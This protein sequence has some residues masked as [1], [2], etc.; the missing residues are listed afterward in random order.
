M[1]EPTRVIEVDVG[2]DEFVGCTRSKARQKIVR[3]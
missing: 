2:S 3:A 1:G